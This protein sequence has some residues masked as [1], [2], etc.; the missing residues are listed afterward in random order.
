MFKIIPNVKIHISTFQCLGVGTASSQEPSGA[1][2]PPAHASQRSPPPHRSPPWPDRATH[3]LWICFLSPPDIPLGCEPHQGRGG[4]GFTAV[5]PGPDLRQI[6][7]M[8]REIVRLRGATP[9]APRA[10]GEQLMGERPRSVAGAN[11]GS[12]RPAGDTWQSFFG[13][14]PG[15]GFQRKYFQP[16]LSWCSG[17]SSDAILAA[18]SSAH[19]IKEEGRSSFRGSQLGVTQRVSSGDRCWPGSG[20]YTHSELASSF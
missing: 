19:V 8:L 17:T 11:V 2:R 9:G 3:K 6:I 16:C 15:Q 1:P 4:V 12:A 14:S 13:L 20:R 7:W 10:R 5:F 18:S